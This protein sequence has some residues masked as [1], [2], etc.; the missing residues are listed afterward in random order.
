MYIINEKKNGYL[1]Y[2]YTNEELKINHA[3][4]GFTR[5]GARRKL[6]KR[7]PD[8]VTIGARYINKGEI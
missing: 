7:F 5:R 2:Y 8:I 4:G 3:F 1:R 6:A